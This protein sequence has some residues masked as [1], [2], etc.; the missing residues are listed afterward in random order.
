[1]P[2]ETSGFL[3]G[4]TPF[5]E[6]P[7]YVSDTKVSFSD[8]EVKFRKRPWKSP[9]EAVPTPD[10][11]LLINGY[12][13]KIAVLIRKKPCNL[14]GLY[15]AQKNDNLQVV[16]EVRC[17]PGYRG[18][19]KISGVL[20]CVEILPSFFEFLYILHRNQDNGAP[21]TNPH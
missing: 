9:V 17:R 15:C 2:G 1:M 19:R 11:I 13:S 18:G 20:S 6:L 5:Q 16:R 14:A 10:K 8:G 21:N 12:F 7:L 3:G 4:C